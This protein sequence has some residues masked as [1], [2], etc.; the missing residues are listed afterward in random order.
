MKRNFTATRIQKAVTVSLAMFLT[1]CASCGQVDVELPQA[2]D[3]AARPEPEECVLDVSEFAGPVGIDFYLNELRPENMEM[4]C[5]SPCTTLEGSIAVGQSGDILEVL[6]H[7]HTI[8]GRL[9]ISKAEGLEDLRALSSLRSA[10]ELT[11]DRNP[12]LVD[13][14]G[15][16]NLTD[17]LGLRIDGNDSLTSTRGLALQ[18]KVGAVFIESNPNLLDVDGFEGID[19]IGEDLQILFNPNLESL[20]G[21]GNLRSIGRGL[22]IQSADALSDFSALRSLESVGESIRFSNNLALVRF[23][24]DSLREFSSER[25]QALSL[26]VSDHPLLPECRVEELAERLSVLEHPGY[27][28]RNNEGEGACP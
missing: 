14:D 8:D 1:S 6:S 16:Q 13:L 24:L 22:T 28:S 10:G 12:D 2:C 26:K 7:V 18:G 5:S 9:T 20:E 17:L 3:P 11:L 21:F 23:G 4:V 19:E 27:S 25:P 15:L